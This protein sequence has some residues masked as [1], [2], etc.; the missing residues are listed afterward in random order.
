MGAIKYN[1]GDKV[2]IKDID[3]YN[4][5]K[6]KLGDILVAYKLF[7]HGV[8]TW[9]HARFTKNM[10]KYCGQTLTISEYSN[11]GYKMQECIDSG[12]DFDI[13]TDEMIECK[14]EEENNDCEK[15]GLTRNSTRCLFM[16]NCPHNK[17]KNIF[18]I[19]KDYILKD[20]YGNIIDTTKI[21]L[22]KKRKYPKTYDECCEVLGIGSYFEPE[23]RNAT[24]EECHKFTKLMRLKRC[25]DAYWKLY[26]EE[27]GLGKP[28]EPDGNPVYAITRNDGC[29]VEIETGGNDE[30]FEFPTQKIRNTFKKN[31]DP[32]IEFCKEF[33]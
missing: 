17:Q 4:E 2:L 14:V 32:D 12:E 11:M 27:M 30:V 8:Y 20:E 9:E 21:I 25:R 26:G 6:N 16:D 22:E 23:I 29:I 28:W 19:P 1:I 7:S 33:L 5:N 13:W 24:T 3:W 15:C 31:F 10:S 18:E